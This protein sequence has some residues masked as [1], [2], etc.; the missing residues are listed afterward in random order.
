MPFSGPSAAAFIAALIAFS[1]ASFSS[2]A[3][4][5]TTDTFGVGTRTAMPSSLPFNAGSTSP[6]AFAAPVEVGTIDRAAARAPG[7][8]RGV[9]LRDDLNRAS[10][11]HDGVAFGLDRLLERAVD[12]VV[13][14]QMRQR[15]RVRDVVDR[16][17]I[18]LRFVER[19]PKEHPPDAAEAVD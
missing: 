15:R 3:V 11:D 8:L 17:D 19:R 16:D 4:R 1:S 18:E 6:I 12:R 13:F 14:E 5:S 10:V 9:A 2:A 7:K